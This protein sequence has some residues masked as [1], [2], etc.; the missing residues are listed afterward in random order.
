M[1]KRGHG[2]DGMDSAY[3][4]SIHGKDI[5]I[6]R[7]VD[8]DDISHLVVN[9]QLQWG[10][11]CIEVNA[12]QVMHQQDLTVSLSTIARLGPFR[13][14]SNLDHDHVSIGVVSSKRWE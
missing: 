12:V 13:G 7:R 8:A 6:E 1:S 9:F 3:R 11:R 5:L 10:H 2:N 14:L 4:V